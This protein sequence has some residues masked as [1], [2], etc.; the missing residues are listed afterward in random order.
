LAVFDFGVTILIGCVIVPVNVNAHVEFL[1]KRFKVRVHKAAKAVRLAGESFFSIEVRE[2]FTT[3]DA[4][5]HILV[6]VNHGVNTFLSE[7]VDKGFNLAEVVVVVDIT[8][9]FNCLPHDAETDKV[10]APVYQVL[11]VF[12][13][14]G[15]L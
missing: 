9:S 7:L 14:K 2:T 11:N 10:K 8:L 12:I 4:S 13:V 15:I 1:K 6:H 5:K 3:H